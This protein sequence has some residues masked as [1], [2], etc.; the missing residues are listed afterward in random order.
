[1]SRVFITGSSDGH[2]LMAARLL[3]DEGHRVTL[4]ARNDT[5]YA[6]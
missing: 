5:V 6:P 4:H 1:M 3:V 2:G